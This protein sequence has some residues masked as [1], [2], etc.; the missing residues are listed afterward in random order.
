MFWVKYKERGFRDEPF[1]IRSY[2]G[3]LMNTFY[4]SNCHV[5]AT[6]TD[7]EFYKQCHN[8]GEWASGVFAAPSQELPYGV[9][10]SRTHGVQI[11][12]G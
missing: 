3:H 8:C 9:Y 11:I 7:T 5:F 2:N 12:P 10:D 1:K 6:K 4:C